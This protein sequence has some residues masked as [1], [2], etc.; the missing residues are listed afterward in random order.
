MKTIQFFVM[1]VNNI[2]FVYIYYDFPRKW[3]TPTL[4]KNQNCN[5]NIGDSIAKYSMYT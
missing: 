4:Y 3:S 2:D 1:A 5:C